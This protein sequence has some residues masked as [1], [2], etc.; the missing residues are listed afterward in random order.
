VSS[1]TASLTP[2]Q[3]KAQAAQKALEYIRDGQILG[4]GTGSTV[5]HFLTALGTR[6]QDGLSIR[7]VPTSQA[8][9]T[10]ATQLGIPLLN[11]D[12]PWDIDVAVDGADQVDPQLNLIKGGGGALLREKIVARAARQFIVIVDEAKQRP[13]LGL[14]FPLPV[15]ILSFGWRTTQRHLEKMGWPAPR[16]DQTG[17]PFLTDNGNYIVDLHIPHIADPASLETTLLQLPGVVECGLFVHMASLVITGTDQGVCLSQA[18]DR[19]P[20]LIQ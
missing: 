3:H 1:S 7:G 5:H 16:R 4:L 13:H 8:T 6:V 9:A 12:E 20:P 18:S 15:E 11:N 19:P 14:P 10:Y 2:D 17:Q